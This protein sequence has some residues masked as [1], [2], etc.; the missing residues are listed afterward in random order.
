[1]EG[2]DIVLNLVSCFLSELTDARNPS[3][4]RSVL[5]VAGQ[6][7]KD[8]VEQFKFARVWGTAVHDGTQVKADY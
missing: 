8:F 6:V 7:H 5:D 2:T 3:G 1:M 4:K